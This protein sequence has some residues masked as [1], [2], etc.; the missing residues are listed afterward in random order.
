M[1]IGESQLEVDTKDIFF[2]NE[3]YYEGFMKSIHR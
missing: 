1:Y 3:I 2:Q